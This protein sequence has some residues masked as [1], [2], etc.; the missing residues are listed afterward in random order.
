MAIVKFYP[1][2]GMKPLF[3]LKLVDTFNKIIQEL[4]IEKAE[5]IIKIALNIN[6]NRII[7]IREVEDSNGDISFIVI[8]Y[9]FISKYKRP[10]TSIPQTEEGFF[11]FNIYQLDFN[12]TID[13]EKIIK[14]QKK[15]LI[16]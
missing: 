1:K 8:L 5:E 12:R 4:G 6:K 14:D 13:I 9:D 3:A 16:K 2:G 10:K 15:Y 7:D 11:D